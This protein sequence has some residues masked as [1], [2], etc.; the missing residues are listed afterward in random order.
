MAYAGVFLKEEKRTGRMAVLVR[1]LGGGR[2]SKT[3]FI[4]SLD[5]RNPE[6]F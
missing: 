2:E 1:L 5:R 4:V 6:P 3:L